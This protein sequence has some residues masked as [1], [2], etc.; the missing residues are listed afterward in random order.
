MS[1][2]K[3]TGLNQNRGQHYL[4]NTYTTHLKIFLPV[5]SEK[6]VCFGFSRSSFFM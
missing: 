6:S 4:T 1:R 2:D 3:N 5:I